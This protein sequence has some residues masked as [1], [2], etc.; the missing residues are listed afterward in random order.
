MNQTVEIDLINCPGHLLLGLFTYHTYFCIFPA[1]ILFLTSCL[2]E[3]S[4]LCPLHLFVIRMKG[5]SM[6][7]SSSFYFQM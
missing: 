7:D 4:V 2:L 3:V 5:D 6:G 1:F